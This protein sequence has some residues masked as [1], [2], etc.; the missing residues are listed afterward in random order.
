MLPC[1]LYDIPILRNQVKLFRMHTRGV[2]PALA[3]VFASS[4]LFERQVGV[5]PDKDADELF[6]NVMA[7][8][9]GVRCGVGRGWRAGRG[10]GDLCVCEPA[11]GRAAH[12]KGIALCCCPAAPP[13]GR[14]VGTL[15]RCC[16]CCCCC[17]G[18]AHSVSAAAVL[19]PRGTD[20]L[21]LHLHGC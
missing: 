21:P 9:V 15:C 5:A 1:S 10:V 4:S 16:R 20:A 3:S 17:H 13:E 14:Q 8:F 18:C 12:S 11:R 2:P 19:W 7:D 6:D